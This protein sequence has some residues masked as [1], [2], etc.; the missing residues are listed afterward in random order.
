VLRLGEH[1]SLIELSQAAF[2]QQ[3]NIKFSRLGM[4]HNACRQV[5][6]SLFKLI[7]SAVK[8]ISE[9]PLPSYLEYVVKDLQILWPEGR[10]IFMTEGH[11]THLAGGT[12]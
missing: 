12:P 9:K 6:S 3:G 10:R 2:E 4:G 7:G 1:P 11:G 5:A 8:T